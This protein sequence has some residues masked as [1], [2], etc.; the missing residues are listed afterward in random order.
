M[1]NAFNFEQR[2]W[3]TIQRHELPSSDN[4]VRLKLL[5]RLLISELIKIYCKFIIQNVFQLINCIL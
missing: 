2:D 5:L 4:L 1:K 3:F